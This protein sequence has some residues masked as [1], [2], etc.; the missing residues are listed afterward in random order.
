MK[1]IFASGY[2]TGRASQLQFSSLVVCCT[3]VCF[4]KRDLN[5][6]HNTNICFQM[7][8]VKYIETDW[9]FFS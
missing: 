3:S 6:F 1:T 9:V 8:D 2:E 7:R 4:W 5:S